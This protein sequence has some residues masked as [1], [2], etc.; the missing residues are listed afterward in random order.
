MGID[1]AT[2]MVSPSRAPSLA[3][4]ATNTEMML[5][6]AEGGVAGLVGD[7]DSLASWV[8]PS[9]EHLVIARPIQSDAS[10]ATTRSASPSGIPEDDLGNV[11]ALGAKVRSP[12]VV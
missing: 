12:K 5:T 7:L 4:V 8:G 3:A 11:D 6:V 1:V 10:I 9:V 2:L